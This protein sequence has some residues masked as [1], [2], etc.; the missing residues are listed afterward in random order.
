[1]IGAGSSWI[2]YSSTY[3]AEV[4]RGDAA[5]ELSSCA[6]PTCKRPGDGGVIMP[7]STHDMGH[8]QYSGLRP[9]QNA[10]STAA[11]RHRRLLLCQNSRAPAPRGRDRLRLDLGSRLGLEGETHRTLGVAGSTSSITCATLARRLHAGQ[12]RSKAMRCRRDRAGSQRRPCG[13]SPSV[14]DLLQ[15]RRDLERVGFTGC[16]ISIASPV[17]VR[18]CARKL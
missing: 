9:G 16:S 7:R 14:L 17:C 12:Q 5:H 11:G 10:S 6:H 3:A 4:A 15:K 1:M 18:T 2:S 8:R 13:I